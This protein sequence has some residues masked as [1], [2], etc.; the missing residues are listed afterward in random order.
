MLSPNHDRQEDPDYAGILKNKRR[1]VWYLFL[2]ETGWDLGL[3][4]AGLQ[5]VHLD[6]PLLKQLRNYMQATVAI[7]DADGVLLDV[8]DISTGNA[9]GIFP[10]ST[11]V[12]RANAEDYSNDAALMEGNAAAHV[13]YE[14]D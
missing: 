10:G 9:I 12:M 14:L 7:E 4:A 13:L 1:I 6:T 3:S 5:C 2:C 11:M 8:C